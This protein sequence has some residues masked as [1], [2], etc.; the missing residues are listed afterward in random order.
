MATCPRLLTC[1]PT[2]KFTP[3]E[4]VFTQSLEIRTGRHWHTLHGETI[5]TDR[6]G[7]IRAVVGN[8]NYSGPFIIIDP[9]H[10][11]STRQVTI[12]YFYEPY[13]TTNMD[14]DHL[15]PMHPARVREYQM[16]HNFGVRLDDGV[17]LFQ[18][19]FSQG[20]NAIKDT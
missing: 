19:V 12:R 9:S 20:N 15:V 7:F 10:L 17:M 16:L 11:N 5:D 6:H 3:G 2:Y 1:D 18:Q 13:W 4:W 14:R 8:P